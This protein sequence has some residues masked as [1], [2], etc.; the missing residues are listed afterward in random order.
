VSGGYPPPPPPLLPPRRWPAAAALLAP[1]M[2]YLAAFMVL[3]V[4]LVV[5]YAFF[6]RG[7]FGGVEYE[8]TLENFARATETVYV[9]VLLTSLGVAAVTTLLALL[10]GY[11]T[12]Y[13]IARMP[14]RRRTVALVLVLLPFW[15]NFL[16]RTYAWI[17]LLNDAGWV[18]AGLM[19]LGLVEGPIRMLYTTP[20]VVTGLL[21]IYLPLM[22]LPLYSALERIDPQLEE[23]ATNLGASRW[24][25][26]RTVTIPLSMPGVLTGCVFVFVPSMSNF[27]V[28]ELL[29]GGKM[30]L[31]GNLV[32]DQFL[33]ARDWPFGS[34]LALAIT[35][36]LVGLLVLQGRAIARY[37]RP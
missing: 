11:P 20:A 15:T 16:I 25:V 2:L 26:F 6:R 29:G 37:G 31:V 13:V 34:V 9:Q 24:R 8:L 27:V 18:N 12:A 35:A 10:L 7:R 17:L 33:R 19:A 1:G 21:Y 14:R 30:L 28:P 36:T 4:G 23:A 22:V 32:R 5:A 3:P